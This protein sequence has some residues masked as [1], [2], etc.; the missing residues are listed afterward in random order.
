MKVRKTGIIAT[1]AIATLGLIGCEDK[2]TLEGN[3]IEPIP[4]MPDQY[5][6]FS[7]KEGGEATS[8]N[9]ATLLYEQWKQEGTSLIVSG[10][11]IGNRQTSSFTDTLAIEKLTKDSLVLKKGTMEFRYAKTNEANVSS[12]NSEAAIQQ[13]ETRQV[14]GTLVIGDE[15]RSF[16]EVGTSTPYWVIDKTDALYSKYDELTNGIKNGTPI[17]AELEIK[18]IEPLKEGFGAS[19]HG[20]YEVVGIHKLAIEE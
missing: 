4:G 10:K 1:V 14:K 8:I 17:Y 15:V 13:Q 11:S 6:G 19:Y 2:P 12:T 20:A 7:L 18:R 16:T 3:W 5:Q 9:S